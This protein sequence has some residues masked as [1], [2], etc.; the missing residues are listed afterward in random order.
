MG[1]AILLA[2]LLVL[3]LTAC[4]DV[5]QE[6]EET[7]LP[8]AETEDNQPAEGMQE[9]GQDTQTPAE[10][11]S[12]QPVSQNPQQAAESN[13][14]L[15]QE[16][17]PEQSQTDSKPTVTLSIACV[18]I[19]DNEAFQASSVQSTLP[20]DG[21]ILSP[22]EVE[23]AEGDSVFDVLLRETKGRKIHLE[24]SE[25]PAFQSKYVEGMANLYQF[26]FGDQSGWVYQVNGEQYNIGSSRYVPKAGDTI[27]WKYID[28]Q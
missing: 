5:G 3:S 27:E 16:F 28:E 23:L 12:E 25:N 8:I 4:S 19:L 26:D 17:K 9:T 11:G 10:Q 15:T 18:G 1:V 21:W 20:E 14:Q 6:P 24:Y 2:V 13:Q 7:S 22:T